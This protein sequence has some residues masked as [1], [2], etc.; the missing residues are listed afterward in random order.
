MQ[1]FRFRP[2]AQPTLLD[3]RSFIL[4]ATLAPVGNWLVRLRLQSASS[5]WLL[6][7]GPLLHWRFV[8]AKPHD[9]NENDGVLSG[10]T[11]SPPKCPAIGRDDVRLFWTPGTV[12]RI[13]FL[14]WSQ[15]LPSFQLSKRMGPRQFSAI[16]VRTALATAP[17]ER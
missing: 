1:D 11:A 5:L 6:S 13:H 2:D 9:R 8:G 7:T 3:L 15:Q 17:R 16:R 10:S 4:G 12:G 14:E